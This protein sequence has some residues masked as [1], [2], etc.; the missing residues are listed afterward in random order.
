V[1][2]N[3][4]KLVIANVYNESI[5]IVDLSSFSLPKDIDLRPGKRDPD[6]SGV[7]GGEYPFWVVVKGNDVAYISSVRDREIVVVNIGSLPGISRRIKIKGNPNKMI[8]DRRQIFLYV[9]QDNSD[10]VT[11]I[12]T[13]S[14]NVVGTVSTVGPARDI[15]RR[16][17][18]ITEALQ[19]AWRSLLTARRCMSR[20]EGP[21]LSR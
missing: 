16:S 11:V 13:R 5:S 14:N 9:A 2:S 20:M 10:R 1:T 18:I 12:D 3:G 7:P 4:S 6:K 15:L 17:Y 21:T 8:L 19:M